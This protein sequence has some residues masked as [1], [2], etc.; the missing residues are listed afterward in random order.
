VA[1]GGW[2]DAV[3]SRVGPPG[4]R[5]PTAVRAG[6]LPVIH[7]RVVSPPDLTEQIVEVLVA[8]SD[9]RD[10]VVLP[11]G[12]RHPD[13]DVVECDLVDSAANVAIRELRRLE[14]PRRGSVVLDPVDLVLAEQ[15]PGPG[16]PG[17]GVRAR[18]PVWEVVEARI[19]ADT[20]Y[21]ARFHLFLVIAGLIGAVGI[22]TN[23]EIL[24]VGA[25]IVGP[26]YGAICGVVLGLDRHSGRA[27]RRGLVALAVGFG[28]AVLAAFAFGRLV[29]AFDLQ[30]RLYEAGLRPVSALIDTP[31]FFS[32][33]VALLAGI[34]GIVSLAHART[35]T[36]LGVFVSVTTI[37]AASDIGLGSAF[38]SWGE[39][40]GA[41]L[42][43]LLNVVVLTVVGLGVL[44]ALRWLWTLIDTADGRPAPGSPPPPAG[45]VPPPSG[46]G[47]AIAR[48][49]I[50][51]G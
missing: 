12:A 13:G 14:V 18:E 16:Q 23:S 26:E 44:R 24:I 42:Q 3:E 36:L 38:D 50:R 45:T 33:V 41:L 11:G 29:R 2:N 8:G 34:V 10:L 40:G 27:V 21:G 17:S 31:N 32:L 22:L 19:R 46:W 30:P 28:M 37:P 20:A 43:L 5:S 6:G 35:S 9:A 7:L 51:P 1:A 4:D 48:R 49:L 47:A 15:V 39:A 25:M